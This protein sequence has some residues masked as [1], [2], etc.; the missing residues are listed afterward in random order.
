MVLFIPGKKL[1]ASSSHLA[2]KEY[3]MKEMKELVDSF[4]LDMTIKICS[5]IKMQKREISDMKR[6]MKYMRERGKSAHHR[7]ET[8]ESTISSNK[9]GSSWT[10]EKQFHRLNDIVQLSSAKN[11][12]Q[13]ICTSRFTKCC[14]FTWQVL[15]L[16]KLCKHSPITGTEWLPSIYNWLEIWH[17]WVRCVDQSWQP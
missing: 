4:Y 2:Y 3:L 8:S 14:R 17:S 12:L 15:G 11:N 1:K 16:F 9:M 5:I 6:E 10:K 7:E 13:P